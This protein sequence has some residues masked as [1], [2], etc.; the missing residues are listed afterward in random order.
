MK[1]KQAI[2]LSALAVA[3]VAL[4]SY[5]LMRVN[6]DMVVVPGGVLHTI[7][8]ET[9]SAKEI[10]I[11]NFL[12]DKNLVTVGDFDAFVKATGF[13][14]EAEKFGNA[15]VFDDGTRQWIL[16][17]G[18]D[19]H[20][21]QGKN[22]PK[23]ESSHPATQISWNDAVAYAKWK[24][25]RLPTQW[26]WEHAAKNGLQGTEQYTWG[27]DLV[28]NGKYKANTWQGSFPSYN[29]VEDGYAYT[30]PVGVFGENKLGLTDMGGNVWQWC[31]DDIAPTDQEKE[32]DPSMRKVLRGGS[33]LCDP[34]VC[35]G[36]QVTGRSSSTAESSLMHAGFRCAKDMWESESTSG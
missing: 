35:H 3:G 19:Y 28:V 20:F 36:F 32:S 10:S 30:S 12:L 1:V 31:E 29:S 27:P 14:T 23:A 18:A 34:L 16:V 6:R 22:K 24:G 8:P 17:D 11:H 9:K 13:Q 4:L 21:P 25:K 26:E 15:A 33:F 5:Q 2:T 7:D